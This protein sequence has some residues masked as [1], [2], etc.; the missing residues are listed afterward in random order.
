MDKNLQRKL[1]IYLRGI[2]MLKKMIDR[3]YSGL[4]DRLK[5]DCKKC[6]GL[7]CVALYCMKT[8]GFPANK[9][10]GVPC[11]Y[12]RTDFRCDI[13]A[14]L[15]SKNMRG[16]LAYDCFGAGQKVT[17]NCFP[18]V[19]WKSSPNHTNVIFQVF[20]IVFQLHQMEWYLLEALS[21]T[22]DE[23]LKTDIESLISE[24]ERMTSL[25][26][27]E[28]LHLNIEDYRSDVNRILKQ[29]SGM[30]TVSSD[31]KNRKD[32]FGHNFKH[33]DLDRKDFSMAL[34][35]AA[36][37]EGCSL[38]GANFL[39]ADMRDANIKNT[40]LSSSVFLTQMQINSAKGNANTKLPYRISQPISWQEK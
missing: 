39:G 11:Q 22:P 4:E 33:A 26:P 38:H 40:D 34:L 20:Q 1:F 35:I 27:D 23:H 21:L 13:H 17:Q 3:K 31:K 9:E 29:L 16:C 7:C 19:D 12:L 14:K 24:N 5:I 15:G 2:K 30:I 10:A 36:N 25:P 28:I 18:K 6:S 37:F 8:D 32:Y